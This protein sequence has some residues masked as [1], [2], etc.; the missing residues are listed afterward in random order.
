MEKAFSD[1]TQDVSSHQ[2]GFLGQSF[3]EEGYLLCEMLQR[4]VPAVHPFAFSGWSGPDW[5]SSSIVLQFCVQELEASS[6]LRGTTARQSRCGGN[7]S[8]KC[9]GGIPFPA[10]PQHL[11]SRCLSNHPSP[12]QPPPAADRSHRFHSSQP[13]I[14]LYLTRCPLPFVRVCCW[15]SLLRWRSSART[16]RQQPRPGG[17]LSWLTREGGEW[18][19]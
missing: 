18:R 7:F 12:A 4:H 15:L 10:S 9:P 8:D 16:S 11:T 14:P 19:V 1:P 6:C 2:E 17:S 5:Q 13:S 3:L